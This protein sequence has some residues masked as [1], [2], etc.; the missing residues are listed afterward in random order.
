MSMIS[1]E[2]GYEPFHLL[3]AYD[4]SSPKPWVFVDVGGSHGMV[5]IALA[6]HADNVHCIVQDLPDVIAEGRSKLP[7]HLSGKVEFMEHDFFAEQPVQ[8]ADVYFFRWIFHDWSD[9]YCVRLLRALIPALKDGARIII[10]DFTIPPPC[11]VP[12]YS[13]WL[14]RYATSA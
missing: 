11:V 4:W 14:I 8:G 9:K 10:S 5:T 7:P 6:Q 13:E 3:K 12:R 2:E 1:Q